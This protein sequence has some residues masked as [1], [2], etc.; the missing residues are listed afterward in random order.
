MSSLTILN[1]RETNRQAE[2]RDLTSRGIIPHEHELQKRPEKSLEGRAWLL[3]RVSALIHD[4]L[5][6]QQIVDNMVNDA[7]EA[8]QRGASLVQTKASSKL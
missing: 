1:C 2:I 6:A 5:P 3:G 8:L 4:V 7:S